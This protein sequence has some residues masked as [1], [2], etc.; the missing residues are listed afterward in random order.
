VAIGIG[1]GAMSFVGSSRLALIAVFLGA[2]A[3]AIASYWLLARETGAV[4]EPDD[5][6]LV[7]RG[8]AVYQAHC[9]SCHGEDLEGEP[10]WHEQD[11]GGYLPAPPH[12]ESGHT[13]H[14]PDQLLFEITKRGVAEAAGLDE[15]RSRMP[16]FEGVLSDAEIIAALSYIK[17]RWPEDVRLRH[18]QLNRAYNRSEAATN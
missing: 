7:A 14:H 1:N 2:S 15:H 11:E 17:S 9:A 18:D 12:D 3:I 13:W 10:N 8:E 16:A 4:L 5:A 6:D